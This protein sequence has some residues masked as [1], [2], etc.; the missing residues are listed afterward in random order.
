[1][2]CGVLEGND[3][4]SL[5]HAT[6]RPGSCRQSIQLNGNSSVMGFVPKNFNEEVTGIEKE[7]LTEVEVIATVRV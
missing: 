5:K 3:K 7:T 4:I 1:M 2:F 6:S